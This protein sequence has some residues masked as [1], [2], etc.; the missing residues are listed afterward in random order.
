[1][2]D[3]IREGVTDLGRTT[4]SLEAEVADGNVKLQVQCMANGG[5]PLVQGKVQL[6]KITDENLCRVRLVLLSEF[7]YQLVFE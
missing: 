7:L 2:F 4:M 5:S 6:T 3:D 1:M